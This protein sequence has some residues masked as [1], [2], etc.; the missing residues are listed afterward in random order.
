MADA[1]SGLQ[2]KGPLMATIRT[3]LG[4]LQC[5]LFDSKAPVT[6]ANFVG[7]ARGLRPF[8]DVSGD[9]VSRPL[10]DGTI[11]HRVIPGFMIQGGDPRGNGSGEP[12]YVIPDENWD[13]AKHDRA[14]LLCM[15]NRGP[16]TNG[17]QF[18]ITDAGA[19]HLD[20]NYTIFGDCSPVSV[21]HAIANVPSDGS[22][23]RA[24]VTILSIEIRRER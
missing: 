21:V 24:D 9:W 19:P 20:K 6:V 7:L 8:K 11:F 4:E 12:G 23:P 10:Y 3:S 5:E 14:G 18:F 17:A 1:T 22:K 15:A 16:N 2:G 13:G